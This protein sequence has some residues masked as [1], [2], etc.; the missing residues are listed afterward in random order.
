M[1][2]VK[3][4]RKDDQIDEYQA[5]TVRE[6]NKRITAHEWQ[7]MRSSF[8]KL[9][10]GATSNDY[11][12]FDIETA[13]DADNTHVW[14]YHWQTYIYG[15]YL[16][17]GRTWAEWEQLLDLLTAK[18]DLNEN[19][20][21]C[22]FIHNADYEFSF[23]ARR[24]KW[25]SM[26]ARAVH[27]PLKFVPERW[28]GIVY[29]DSYALL[30]K[31]L[32]HAT[33][34]E[35]ECDYIKVKDLDYNAIYTPGSRLP[36]SAYR[37]CA[38]DVIGLYQCLRP[39]VRR[40]K[41]AHH[42]PLTSTGMIRKDA[43]ENYGHTKVWR[44]LVRDLTLDAGCYKLYRDAARGGD[45]HAQAWAVTVDA[46]DP[47]RWYDIYSHDL[48]SS[49]PYQMVA[50]IYPL[51]RPNWVDHPTHDNLR[52][53]RSHNY[54]YVADIELFDV[55]LKDNIYAR[56]YIPVD[57]CQEKSAERQEDNGRIISASYIRIAVVYTDF[58]LI[59]RYYNFKLGRIHRLLYH[60]VSGLLPECFRRYVLDMYADKTT[61]KGVPGEEENYML[62]KRGVNGM[63]GMCYSRLLHEKIIINDNGEWKIK[64]IQLPNG[65]WVDVYNTN[66]DLL[67]VQGSFN[68]F[69]PYPIGVF[70]ASNARWMLHTALSKIDLS[71]YWD[72][73]S[74]KSISEHKAVF[75][76]INAGIERNLINIG[77]KLDEYAPMDRYGKRHPIGFWES[78]KEYG[79]GSTFITWGAK[80]YGLVSADGKSHLTVAGLGA[81][82]LDYL[83]LQNRSAVDIKIGEKIPA[84]YAGRLSAQYINEPFDIT[85][86]GEHIHED[87][88]ITLSPATYTFKDVDSERLDYVN[89]LYD[90]FLMQN[91]INEITE[92]WEE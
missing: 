64:Q 91:D 57:K 68:F 19:R 75:D 56:T 20:T 90:R 37:Y 82:A 53:L 23:M 59:A 51:S 58:E 12:T 24:Y 32:E 46:D 83:A 55:Q 61:L 36:A 85:V 89:V 80:K 87:S 76:K 39:L 40:Y 33:I 81:G 60:S 9:R 13:H 67:K 49:Y 74:L 25:Q 52:F 28:P 35:R 29:R 8:I 5:L 92:G 71:L 73:D 21:L 66:V 72:T 27:D 7:L 18:L 11:M 41:S 3:L 10:T 2:T 17:F 26:F 45:T 69:T 78:E 6:L 77:Y 42:M 44:K 84:E 16:V 1:R 30:Q 47:R 79:E 88:Y 38:I 86:N 14:L 48:S 22:C 63:F 43:R 65:Q 70:T 31:S 15:K 62:K 50:S 54:I 4:K 34:D